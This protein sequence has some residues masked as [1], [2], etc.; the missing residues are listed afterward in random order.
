MTSSKSSL[1]RGGKWGI[2]WQK[3]VSPND[4]PLAQ[5]RSALIKE[6]RRGKEEEALYWML[7]MFEMGAEVT[8][9]MWIDLGVFTH[10]DAGLADPQATGIVM[11]AKEL[12]ELLPRDDRRR[13]LTLA[14]VVCYLARAKKTRYVSEILGHVLHARSIGMTRPVPDYAI[15]LHTK[16]GRAMGRG[17]VHYLTEGS[18]LEND[19]DGFDVHYWRAA[20]ERAKKKEGE[21]K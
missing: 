10:E 6:L 14:Q 7:E 1:I 21:K 5:V 20:F 9:E 19:S 17:L 4:H 12:Y 15:D 11:A 2:D 18:K 3:S 13:H 16:E 8:E